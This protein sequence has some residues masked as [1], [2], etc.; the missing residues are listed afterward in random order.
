MKK[1]IF[2]NEVL[3]QAKAAL[4][5][6]ESFSV[7]MCNIDASQIGEDAC[8]EKLGAQRNA[9]ILE[10][11][12]LILTGT[13]K[14]KLASEELSVEKNHEFDVIYSEKEGLGFMFDK[15][16]PITSQSMMSALYFDSVI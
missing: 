16:V 2:E 12:E 5:A 14:V 13:L 6:N 3:E 8:H 10:D 9:L 15:V 4:N 11:N 1:A 7:E